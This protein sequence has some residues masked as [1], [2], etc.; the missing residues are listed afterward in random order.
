M[1]QEFNIDCFHFVYDSESRELVCTNDTI[2]ITDVDEL[3]VGNALNYAHALYA[4]Y[5]KI[6]GDYANLQ[7]LYIRNIMEGC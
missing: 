6:S 7:Q 3:N 1:K 4:Y 2:Y 5:S